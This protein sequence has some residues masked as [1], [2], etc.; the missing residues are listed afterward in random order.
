[1]TGGSWSEA[2]QTQF[3]DAG[4]GGNDLLFLFPVGFFLEFG[5]PCNFQQSFLKCPGFPQ[6]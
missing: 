1:M 3:F 4:G 5:G 2:T 6:W